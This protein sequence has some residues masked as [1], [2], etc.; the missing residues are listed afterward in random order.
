[1][2]TAEVER[3][4]FEN[5]GELTIE[6]FLDIYDNS[7]QLQ[8]CLYDDNA[9]YHYEFWFYDKKEPLFFNIKAEAGEIPNHRL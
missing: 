1:M 6:Q 3:M 2:Y 8:A 7:P 9:K 4:I 5:N